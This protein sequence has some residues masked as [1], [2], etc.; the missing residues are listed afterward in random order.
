[1]KFEITYKLESG[2]VKSFITKDYDSYPSNRKYVNGLYQVGFVKDGKARTTWIPVKHG[3]KYSHNVCWIKV[4]E[5]YT[6]RLVDS[7]ECT[8]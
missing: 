4:R 1:M 3:N 2:E 5:A 7:I 8:R 6:G